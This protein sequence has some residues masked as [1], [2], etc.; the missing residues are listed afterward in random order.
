MKDRYFLVLL[1]ILGNLE[2]ALKHERSAESR[3]GGS[4]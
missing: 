3:A 4:K 1:G 2:E